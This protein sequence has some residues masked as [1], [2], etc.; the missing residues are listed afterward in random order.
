MNRFTS[1]AG[2]GDLYLTCTHNQSRNR[3][4]GVQIGANAQQGLGLPDMFEATYEGVHTAVALH[5]YGRR[6]QLHL[7]VIDAVA[8]VLRG[9]AVNEQFDII[10]SQGF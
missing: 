10:S 4:L 2:I 1:V 6:K 3:H 5:E 8:A 7:P 9:G